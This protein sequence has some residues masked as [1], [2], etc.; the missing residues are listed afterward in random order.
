MDQ[1]TIVIV[2]SVLSGTAVIGIGKLLFDLG[3]LK[4]DVLAR[5]KVIE[6]H[7]FD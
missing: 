2:N 6:R 4:G 5:L 3:T 1:T 7:I